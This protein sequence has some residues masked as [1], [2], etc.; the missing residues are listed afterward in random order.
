M[1]HLFLGA[2]HPGSPRRSFQSTD[3]IG[4]WLRQHRSAVPEPRSI[5]H[6]M[7]ICFLLHIAH[8]IGIKGNYTLY[9]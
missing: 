6:Q 9:A 4:S 1:I 7:R 8:L 5:S 3:D 2:N